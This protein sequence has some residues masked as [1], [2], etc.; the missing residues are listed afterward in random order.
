MLQ[1]EVVERMTAS[2]GSSER[3]FLS[4]LVEAYAQ[5]EALFDVEPGAFRPVPKVWSTVARLVLRP[6]VA[7]EVGDETLLWRVVSAG[8]AQRRKTIFNNL[9]HS[10]ADLRSRIDSRGGAER[11]LDAAAIDAQRR[12]ETLTLEEWARL[13]NACN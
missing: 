10:P 3:G 6:R 11:V 7:A 9:R 1:R 5:A 12:A 8:F 4:V 13:A 2:A